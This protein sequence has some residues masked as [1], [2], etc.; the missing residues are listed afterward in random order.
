MSLHNTKIIVKHLLLFAVFTVF[1]TSRLFAQTL[2]IGTV[3]PG[4][5]VSGS[6]I[7]IPFEINAGASYVAQDNT[8][9]LYM[10]D[11]SGNFVSTTPVATLTNTFYATYFNYTIP[12]GLAAGNGYKFMIKASDPA[13]TSAASTAI[14]IDA[15]GAPP[16]AATS[17][18]YPP[19]NSSFPDVSGNCSNPQTSAIFYS[20]QSSGALNTTISFYNETTQ[21]YQVQNQP[22]TINS[23]TPAVANY[24]VTVKAVSGGG[25]VSTRAYQFINNKANT[26]LPSSGSNT[27][28]LSSGGVA[29]LTFG[30]DYT[31][32]AGVQFNYPGDVY[33][34][35]WGDGSPPT[36]YTLAQIIA[37]GGTISHNYTK[38]SCGNVANGQNNVFEVDLDVN[39]KYCARVGTRATSYANITIAPTNFITPITNDVAC[40][41]TSVSFA[42]GS[43]PGPDP[44]ATAASCAENPNA[45]Y[46]WYVDGTLAQANYHRGQNFVYTF[47]TNG[48]HTILLRAQNG[49]GV[50]VAADYSYTI[51]VQNPPQPSLTLPASP[52]CLT[53]GPITPTNTS[54][55]DPGCSASLTYLWSV[56]PSTFTLSGGTTL[57]GTAPPQINFTAP[58][59]YTIGLK[60]TTGCGTYTAT[61]QTITV[62][63][64]PVTTLSADF[65][66]CGTNQTL[67]FDGTNGSKTKSVFSGSTAATY[68]WTVTGG[69]STFTGGTT[70]TSKFPQISFTDYATYTVTVTQT[71][72]CGSTSDSQLISFEQAPAVSAG[73]PQ[74]ICQGNPVHLTGT[75]GGTYT[76]SQWVSSGTGTFTNA[77]AL[78]SDYNPSAADITRGS[79]TLTLNV[80]TG[81]VGACAVVTSTVII[82]IIPTDVVTSAASKTICSGSAISYTITA[83]DVASTYSWTAAVTSGTATGFTASGT[84]NSITDVLTNSNIA[85]TAVIT[86]TITPTGSSGCPGAPF[87]YKVTIPATP[88]ITP[89]A[90]NATICSNQPT[91]ISIASNLTGTTYTWTVAMPAGVTGGHNVVTN[92]NSTTITDVLINNNTTTATVT[93]TITPYNS[94]GCVGTAVPI[95]VNVAPV[96]VT[97]NAGSDASLC[98]A[99]SYVLQ[100]NSPGTGTGLWTVISGSGITFTD[101]TSPTSTIT[102]LQAGSSYRLQWAISTAPGCQSVSTVNITVILP[103]VAGTTAAVGSSTV[104]S[105]GNGGQIT[106][107][108]K[109]GNILRWESSTDNGTTW[110]SIAITATTLTYSNLTQSTQYHAIVQNGSCNIETSNATTITVNQPPPAANAGI[111]QT[112]C[113]SSTAALVGNNPGTFAGMWTQTSG[114]AANIF[115]A[116]QSSTSVSGLVGGN[117]YTFVWTIIALPPCANTQAQMTITVNAPTVA[118]TTAT[119]GQSSVCAGSNGGQI[120]LTGQVG[121]VIRWESSTDNGTTWQ[122][123]SST[124]TT[125]SYSNLV[126]TTQYRAVVQ[127]GNCTIE[128]SN[129]TTITVNQS[130]PAANA[131]ADQNLCNV[132]TASLQANDPGIYSGT[133][134]QISGPAATITSPNSFQTTVSGLT[135]GS[136]YTFLWTIMAN[137]PCVNTTSQVNIAVAPTTVGGTTATT[138]ASTICSG[139]NTG[140]ITLT[141][142]VGSILR[143]EASTDNGATW[144]TILN[145]TA[146]ITYSNLVQTTQYR[147]IVQSGAC[148]IATSTVTT[149]TVNQSPPS[150]NAGVDQMLCGVVT[151]NLQANAPGTFTGIWSQTAG[152]VVTIANAS[153][154]QTTISG[155]SGGNTYTF[156]WTILA[157][158]PCVNT[159]SQVNITVTSATVAG[160]TAVANGSGSVCLG[161][162]NGQI[163]LTGQIGSVLRWEASTDNG[164]TWQV[165]ANTS[166][167]LSFSNLTQTTQYRAVVQSGSC[168]IETSNATTIT[169]NTPPPPA[170]A[171]PNQVL[172]NATTAT[173]TGSDPGTFTGV[174]QQTS[175]PAVTFANANSYQTTISGLA[176]GNA[177]AFTWTIL[178]VSPCV[179]TQAQV[180]ITNS[181]DVIASFTTTPKNGCGD[182]SVQFTNTSN[183]Q[184]G[185]LF[186]WNFGDGSSSNVT[187][188]QHTFTQRTDGR[189]TTYKIS[190]TVLGN[191]APH[192]PVIDSV[193]VRPAT[194]VARILPVNTTGCGSFAL[195]V[196]NV[197]PGNNVSYDFY[198]FDGATLVQKI[199]RTD[200]SDAIFN[201]ISTTA[202][203]TFTLYMV[204]TGYCNNTNETIHIPVTISPPDIVA[205]MFIQ[206]NMT[207]GCAPLSVTFL[208]NSF[209]GDTFHYTIY[210]SNNNIVDQ[211]IAG[212]VS[213][214][215]TFT[216]AGTYYVTVIA[217]NSCGSNESPRTE[218]DVFPIPTPAFAAD[219]TSGC[220]D[221]SVKFINNSISNDP[222]TP[223]TSL[224]YDWDFGDGTTHSFSYQPTHVYHSQGS[225]FTV[226]LT[227]TNITT[228]CSNTFTRKDY[229]TII[230]PPGTN[231]TSDP[232]SVSSIPNYHFAFTDKTT[233]SPISWQWK[234]SDGQ[235]STQ[236]NPQVT[237]ADTGVYKVSLTTV[238][239]TGCDST[240]TRIVRIT[241]TPGQLYLPNAFLP[242]SATTD[243]RVFMAKGS[244]IKTWQL[245]IFNTY[246]Q[247]VWETT[248]LDAAGAPVEGWDGTFKGVPAPQGVYVW[249]ASATFINGTEWKG[250]SYNS[251]PPNRTGVIHLI[252]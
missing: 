187:S 96:P 232:D 136:N 87:N 156:V 97:A 17:N 229:I 105:G 1:T 190:L 171:G 98:G 244:G 164:V 6:T 133:W 192:P 140:Q 75:V 208:N 217:S 184:G 115:D 146:S 121:N 3:D 107:T 123:V 249:Q 161:G 95:S 67:T 51:C 47:T 221:V 43:V 65:S 209:G 55:L 113:N 94:N 216:K 117:T 132:T 174:W 185:A 39:D 199:T 135:G 214:P 154:A 22:L 24:T 186:F 93:Y 143:W 158:A 79:V 32:A 120:N 147:A 11:A 150:A 243:L 14:T 165:I 139:T 71:D 250:M 53:N 193:L 240:E 72:A 245:K 228:G 31:S 166:A 106:L 2:T 219:T 163:L 148:S 60:I 196:Q 122:P 203:K 157:N 12:S 66:L 37:A 74:S 76:S 173:L 169:V 162:N 73:T 189:D 88:T 29:T 248:K 10:S 92:T 78:I 85:V 200:K 23:F 90:A 222:N 177:Y 112:L 234:F 210:D 246:G 102:G 68:A 167:S 45:L 198:L 251:S 211:P 64:P 239:A 183:G 77:A 111:N 118:G 223:A 54:V 104:C 204:A 101:N 235:T 206:N 213:L 44:N 202:R 19:L 84:G 233:G 109:V 28:C 242:S 21:T 137:A 176:G 175:G 153:N 231:F 151:A 110:Q 126:Q 34:Y 224:N 116:S 178:A 149:I 225:P 26:S 52:Y 5:F 18:G 141:G 247:L 27:V 227:V 91:G 237:F 42:N 128:T 4:P 218:V 80:N 191:C 155:L 30:V 230:S 57:T 226:T 170:N 195:D 129:A 59:I 56:S 127:N 130:P 69:A 159:Q 40:T 205:Q 138:G 36:S 7:A 83:S 182:L 35:S 46:E 152:P 131:G 215:Y 100:G 181:T 207:Q 142:Q 124:A 9:S 50:C 15:I 41:G 172:C 114:P 8:F 70:A 180:T 179:N 238:N 188:P 134:T 33:T 220:R 119:A 212:P 236:R 63:G 201:A 125:I 145:T 89:T 48:S 13:I 103:T 168:S 86:Y 82:T 38:P 108:G 144:Q 241:G 81:L 61:S 58:G 49:N 62:D 160:T 20:N 194:P 16:T 25:L 99:T 252:R 197:S